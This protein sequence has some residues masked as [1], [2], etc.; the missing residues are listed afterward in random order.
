MWMLVQEAGA[1]TQLQC[2]S[3]LQGCEGATGQ[4]CASDRGV[5]VTSQMGVT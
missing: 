4:I 5:G 1:Y 2:S 3:P